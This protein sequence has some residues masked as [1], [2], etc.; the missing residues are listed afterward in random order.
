MTG[1]INRGYVLHHQNKDGSHF[2]SS[3][4]DDYSVTLTTQEYIAL[5]EGNFDYL[6]DKLPSGDLQFIVTGIKPDSFKELF[7][8]YLTN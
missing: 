4:D 8:D 7:D 1:A 3:I 6:Y 5:K 2:F